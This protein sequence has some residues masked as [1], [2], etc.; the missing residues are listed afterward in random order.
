MI[1]N[2]CLLKYCDRSSGRSRIGTNPVA[3][4]DFCAIAIAIVLRGDRGLEQSVLKLTCIRLLI[5]IVLRGDRGLELVKRV[6]VSRSSWIAIVLRG[7]RGLEPGCNNTKI[8]RRIHIAIVLRGDRGLELCRTNVGLRF[9]HCDRSSG[10]SRIGTGI[11]DVWT[12]IV[13]YCDRSSGRS[14]IGT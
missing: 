3:A 12:V 13:G 8:Q 14:R 7:D 11:S 2:V 6:S 10:R 9:G 5:A 4:A 1:L